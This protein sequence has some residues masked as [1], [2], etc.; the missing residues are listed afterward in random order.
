MKGINGRQK[1][2]A[3]EREAAKWLQHEFKLEFVPE[4]NIEQ[5]RHKSGSANHMRKSTGHDLTGFQPF[6]FEIKRCETLDL[7]GWWRQAVNSCTPEYSVPV[8]M[9]RQNKRQWKFLI[10]AKEL[11]LRNGYIHL[12]AREFIMFVNNYLDSK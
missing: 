6:A 5:Y 8:V 12:E 11:G 1:G 3:A 4:R 7:R 2:A 10:S 9:Y